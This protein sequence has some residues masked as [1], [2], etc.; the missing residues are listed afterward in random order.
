MALFFRGWLMACVAAA[1]GLTLITAGSRAVAQ[2]PELPRTVVDATY[3]PLTG[4]RIHVPA[5]GNLQAA[6]NA[7][8]PGDTI[9]LEAGAMFSGNFT[10]PRKSSPGWIH[11]QSASYE[12][13]P[14]P[15]RRATPVDSPSMPRIVTPNTA[16]V[17]KT[18]AGASQYRL[19]G[20]DI[21][22]TLQN[23]S[24]TVFNLLDFGSDS[25]SATHLPSDLIVDRCYIHGNQNAN[26]RRGIALNSIRSA[27]VDSYI[28]EI[29]EHGADAQAVG[30]W[31]GPGPYLIQNNFLAAATENIMF[32]GSPPGVA[33][34]V[35][36]DIVI[37]D[38][39][40][41]KPLRW[42][43][44]DPSFDGNDWS[45]KNSFEL[46]NARRV[47]VEGNVFENNWAD[48]QVGFA[49]LFTVRG[50]DGQAPWSA[51]QDVTFRHNIV[52]NSDHGVNISAYDDSGASQQTS[53]ILIANNYWD[54]VGGR[55]FQILN[56]PEGGTNGVTIEHNTSNRAGNQFLNM[57]DTRNQPNINLAVR[58]NLGP[59]GQYG[60][61]GGGVGS[62]TAALD[63][64]AEWTF[65]GN[66]LAGASASAYPPNN[67]YPSNF[68]QDIGFVDAANGDFRLSSSSPYTTDGNDP[69]VD[70]DAL[71][72]KTARARSGLP[73]D[74]LGDFNRDGVVDAADYV[75]WRK[76][77]GSQQHYTVWRANFGRIAGSGA[78]A[79]ANGAVPE[80]SATALCVLAVMSCAAMLSGSAYARRKIQP[81]RT[82]RRLRS[83]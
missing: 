44:S 69:G 55:L 24:T 25:T 4:Q 11:I 60:V 5:G 65:E 62:G 6:I 49:I 37:R 51:V 64:Y 18:Q 79:N 16:P 23:Q 41:L 31:T 15:G 46:K 70:F 82:R 61:F 50:E 17:F 33:N 36:E 73:E 53:R 38:N 56:A 67:F 81:W 1:T 21:G 12:T 35:P 63:A 66:V 29:H 39:H 20:L 78:G 7:A 27:V 48:S 14:E 71:W 58:N 68:P 8:Q 83:N 57:G 45:I 9:E 40:L 32:G 3:S 59:A 19:I 26:V 10:L 76:N 80:P 2:L 54:Q 13:L 42:K 52:K 43:A 34:L 28:D 74:S 72:I 22:A 77:G 47:L 30:G 75:V